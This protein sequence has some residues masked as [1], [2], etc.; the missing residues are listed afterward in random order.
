MKKS[1]KAFKESL[2]QT[3]L[4]VLRRRKI[5]PRHYN[6]RTEECIHSDDYH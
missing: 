5:K 6:S 4:T 2:R 1:K 3:T